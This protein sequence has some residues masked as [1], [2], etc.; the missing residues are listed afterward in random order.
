MHTIK[1]ICG[2]KNKRGHVGI[3][4]EVEAKKF[5]PSIE[6]KPWTSKPETSLRGYGMEY[7]TAAPI[8]CDSDK[9]DALKMLSEVLHDPKYQV[10]HDSPRTSVHVHVNVLGYTPTQVYTAA[11][12]YWL[13]EN[14]LMEWCG[15][16]RVGNKFCLRLKD[17]EGILGIC[18]ADATQQCSP[19]RYLRADACKYGGLNLNAVSRFGSL[20]F[21]GMRGCYDYKTMDLWSTAMY[22]LVTKAVE[23]YESPSALM[24]YYYRHGPYRLASKLLHPELLE[25]ISQKNLGEYVE[26]NAEILCSF[27]YMH[28]W[29]TW[30]KEKDAFITKMKSKP[31]YDL[32]DEPIATIS[33]S[34]ILNNHSLNWTTVTNNMPT[35]TTQPAESMAWKHPL[36]NASTIYV[37]ARSRS[38]YMHSNGMGLMYK[39]HH[40]GF[41]QDVHDAAAAHADVYYNRVTGPGR[42]W[43]EKYIRAYRR[44][45]RELRGPV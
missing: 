19:F 5:L 4:V 7:I 12:A 31:S 22:E 41:Y 3:E 8:L 36:A 40:L 45:Y 34:Q 43:L 25:K 28:N 23:H 10:N 17:A 39:M 18:R 13:L 33:A 37:E 44:S 2:H 42:A 11:C 14:P 9:T 20:E 24:D 32:A 30:A 26:E 16:T 29:D 6:T 1:D 15:P 35:P 27:S 21:R 38:L